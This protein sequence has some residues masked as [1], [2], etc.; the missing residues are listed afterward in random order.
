MGPLLLTLQ[1]VLTGGSEPQPQDA[2]RD[3]ST[4][5]P[6]VVTVGRI[7]TPPKIDGQIDDA[8]WSGAVRI[9]EF[10]QQRPLE[11]APATEQT[12][13]LMAYDERQLYFAIYAHYTDPSIVRANRVDRDQIGRDDAVSIYFDPFLDQQR[14][15]MFSVNGYGVQADALASGTGGGGGGGGFGGGGGGVGGGRPP[16][17]NTGPPQPG[18][19][20]EDSSWDALFY[21]AGHLVEDG[22][23]AELAIPFKSLRYPA[24]Q[25]GEGHRWGF[26]IQRD[27][28]SKNESVVW[29]PVS[30]S[31]MGFLTQMGT[32]GGLQ[33]LSTSRNLELLPTFTAIHAGAIDTSSG[34]Y[35]HIDGGPQAGLNVKYGV[36]SNLI[37]DFTVNPDFSQIESDAAQIEVNQR[38]PLFYSERRPFFLEGQEIFN[39]PAPITMIHTRTIVDPGYGGKMT[40]KVGRT[41]LGVLAANDEAP[42]RVMGIGER[43]FDES[44][45]VFLGRVR[46]D[47]YPESYVGAVITD[48]EFLDG[49]SR[50]G[51]LDAQ[52]KLDATHRLNL[53]YIAT[54]RT[55][56]LGTARQTGSM[57]E[58]F[59]RKEGRNV[60]YQAMHFRVSPEFST[61]LGFVRRVDMQESRGN[62]GY[63]WWPESWVINWGPRFNYSRI[64][65][66]NGVLTDEDINLNVQAQF[67]RNMNINASVTGGMERYGGIDFDRRRFSL[68]GGVNTSRRFSFGGFMNIG[69]QIRY[70]EAPYLGNGL[71]GALFITL[72]P[73]SRLQSQIEINTSR[74]VDPRIDRE[75][76]N[77]KILRALTTYQFTERLLMRNI[78]EVNSFDGTLALNLLGTYRVNSGTVF[79]AGYDDRYRHADKFDSL[80]YPA[81]VFPG[82]DYQ[83]TNRAFFVKL[84]YLFRY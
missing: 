58:L 19:P 34:R 13:V 71:N 29:S 25:R 16:S 82:R 67:T 78:T 33:D 51:G 12:E 54:G 53:K 74:F 14:A 76:F 47:F 62:F 5:A 36:T 63:R 10:V 1:L 38:F 80:T 7:D 30:L 66:Y 69:K 65:D 4:P 28:E 3:S 15:Y 72:R 6:K 73:L 79:F 23:V 22:W 17:G 20:N 60:S 50:L 81:L 55:D 49:Y 84:Q 46:Y 64:Y 8:A 61:A 18:A 2:D 70:I 59:L 83:R 41:S 57:L 44:A 9:T 11:G 43:G 40:G 32:L 42:G 31:I 77:V 52:F 39:I 26:Q 37:S 27:I 24:R 48:R 68:G 75:V 21:S 56:D 45:S 35:E